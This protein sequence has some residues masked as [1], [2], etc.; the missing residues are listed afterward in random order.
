MG[1]GQEAGPLL[2]GGSFAL[3]RGTG[4]NGFN[5]RRKIIDIPANGTL[6]SILATGPV[7]YI[8]VKESQVTSAGAP[9]VPQGFEYRLPN[10]GFT[11]TLATIP[12]ELL[13]IGD[14]MSKR[15]PRGSMIGNGPDMPGM[16]LPAQPATTLFKAESLTATP[17]SIEVTQYY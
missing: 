10:D 4:M 14:P 15:G 12:G 7:R 3:E 11:Q 1:V 2:L 17:T 6:L 16:G 5:G 13:E 9:N 8:E